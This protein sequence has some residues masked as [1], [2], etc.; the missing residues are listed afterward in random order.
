[1]ARA[2]SFFRLAV[3][4]FVLLAALG[5]SAFGDAWKRYREAHPFHMQEIAISGKSDERQEIIISEP[6]PHVPME[7]EQI[8]KLLRNAFAPRHIEDVRFRRHRFMRDGWVRD[9]TAQISAP[10]SGEKAEEAFVDSISALSRYLFGTSHGA[11]YRD[12][13]SDVPFSASEAPGNLS[14]SAAELKQWLF[15]EGVQFKD[16]FSGAA[17]TL[18]VLLR[19]GLRGTYVSSDGQFVAWVIDPRSGFVES[20]P[21]DQHMDWIERED[22]RRFTIDSDVVIGGIRDRTTKYFAVIGQARTVPLDAS[23]PLRH[24]MIRRLAAAANEERSLGQSYERNHALAGRLSEGDHAGW[25]WA[26]IYLSDHLQNTEFGSLLNVTDQLLKS[27]S[28]GGD[29]QYFNFP[30][31]SPGEFPFGGRLDNRLMTE[32]IEPEGILFNWNTAG[33]ASVVEIGNYEYALVFRTGSLPVTYGFK[34]NGDTE[35]GPRMASFEEEGWNY[36]SNRQDPNLARVAQYT[37]LYQIFRQW[38]VAYDDRFDQRKL[39]SAEVNQILRSIVDRIMGQIERR[40]YPPGVDNVLPNL[41]TEDKQQLDHVVNEVAS[42]ISEFTKIAPDAR[43]ALVNTIA[44]PRDLEFD[45]EQHEYILQEYFSDQDFLIEYFMIRAGLW[46]DV[47]DLVQVV[48]RTLLESQDARL[49]FAVVISELFD[50]SSHVGHYARRASALEAVVAATGVLSPDSGNVKTPS[51]VISRDTSQKGADTVGGH[52][53]DSA[54]TRISGDPS[55]AQGKARIATGTDGK[56]TIYVH[57]ADLLRSKNLGRAA[58]RSGEIDP[59][60]FEREVTIQLDSTPP[61]SVE[62]AL[63]T[64]RRLD[65]PALGALR[66]VDQPLDA[67][68]MARHGAA[69]LEAE[70]T[71]N[72]YAGS[73]GIML[74]RTADSNFILSTASTAPPPSHSHRSFATFTAALQGTQRHF[75]EGWHGN[76]VILTGVNRAEADAFRRSIENL[77]VDPTRSIWLGGL[78]KPSVHPGSRFTVIEPS[79][80]PKLTFQIVTDRPRNE[81]GKLKPD[82]V[83]VAD[84]ASQG[85][86]VKKKPGNT[87]PDFVGSEIPSVGRLGDEHYTVEFEAEGPRGR[88]SIV[89]GIVIYSKEI[90]ADLVSRLNTALEKIARSHPPNDNLDSFARAFRN[91]ILAGKGRLDF[92]LYFSVRGDEPGYSIYSD[93]GLMKASAK[94]RQG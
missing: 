43:A 34:L 75:A 37:F 55:V 56:V 54:M 94:E 81:I 48:R 22:F 8:E 76:S 40:E 49:A 35:T 80:G 59:V 19:K 51:V 28:L 84:E 16:S 41:S 44:V 11:Y 42:L 18:A 12:L 77:T 88:R 25:D 26:P 30:Y 79:N 89:M 5:E 21:S 9:I 2:V 31:P 71:L 62:E 24:E 33:S 15:E 86:G 61:R 70:R 13:Q 53:L 10:E 17:G 1:M 3:V 63:G 6:P 50:L 7:I 20:N 85:K 58:A 73:P 72:A 87:I 92:K 82:L 68:I 74:T 36:F 67:G 27:W 14:V 45:P 23:P 90:I 32:G 91:E 39:P 69:T 65:N 83:N 29:I 46:L 4:F 78:R 66:Q 52:S 93:L 57:P 47:Q 38:R 64:A 60:P